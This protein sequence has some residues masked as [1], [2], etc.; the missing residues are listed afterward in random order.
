MDLKTLNISGWDMSN[1]TNFENMTQSGAIT[2]IDMTGI[3]IPTG[4]YNSLNMFV[5]FNDAG[6]GPATITVNNDR[7]VSDW[8]FECVAGSGRSHANAGLRSDTIIV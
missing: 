3:K 6:T 1:V 7:A 2:T 4:T 5:G 8:L